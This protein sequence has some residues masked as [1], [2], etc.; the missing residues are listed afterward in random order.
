[1]DTIGA[2]AFSGC[3]GLSVVYDAMNCI[4]EG[5]Y[6]SP[7]LYA[8]N[9]S[10]GNN[11]QII[12]E[13]MFENCE[14]LS[15]LD[16]PNT[17][18]AIGASAFSGC[19]GLSGNLIIPNS[20]TTIGAGAFSRCSGLSGSLVIPNS[21]TTIGSGAFSG[22]SGLSGNLVVPNSV[23]TI[24]AS[25]FSDCEGIVSVTIGTKV[26]SI[27]QSA[28]NG[29]S[30]LET[31]YYNAVNATE[32]QSPFYFCN[33][34]KILNVGQ[35][36]NRIPDFLMSACSS[37][38][39]IHLPSSLKSIGKK[40]FFQCTSLTS[41]VLPNSV[42]SI[43]EMAFQQ[44]SGLLSV[45]IPNSV[46]TIG[47]GAF[48]G[49]SGALKLTIGTD[50]QDVGNG[51]F[52]YMFSLNELVFNARQL[53][54][55]LGLTSI[56][57]LI[58][59]SIG[60]EVQIIPDSFL[61]SCQNLTGTLSLPSTLERIG[62]NAFYYCG[63]SGE[64]VLPSGLR[65]LGNG[66]FGYCKFSSIKS[67]S[68]IPPIIDYAGYAPMIFFG[69]WDK[70]LYVPNGCKSV[71]SSAAGWSNFTD[72]REMGT[73]MDENENANHIIS[74]IN[75]QIVVD[76]ITDYIPVSL[77]DVMG[78]CLERAS[79]ISKCVF[80]VPASGIYYVKIGNNPAQKVVV[81]Q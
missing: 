27:G 9:V 5:S 67:L 21:V 14:Q 78:R 51:A 54:N 36:V 16:I 58:R 18:V 8:T 81:F 34:L 41:I 32:A 38:E 62:D 63:F 46:R 40:S 28:F 17:V 47:N 75:G 77:Y 15:G 26:E 49:C 48:E 3:Y 74:I 24:G 72:I 33:S 59:L 61:S 25:A 73:G 1:M 4:N 57:S 44:C 43:D 56:N 11:V 22:C 66:A 30:S 12:P 64:L 20:V 79:G 29:M 80:S 42:E 6:G 35:G 69:C 52:N 55:N 19:S 70:P 2:G 7:F 50:V 23:I 10:F 68:S 37:L 45:E 71:Y 76:V 31:I 39:E 53:N 13:R 65:E 60:S